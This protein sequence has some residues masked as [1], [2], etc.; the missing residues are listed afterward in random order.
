MIKCIFVYQAHTHTL[1]RFISSGQLTSIVTV[2]LVLLYYKLEWFFWKMKKCDCNSCIR[3]EMHLLACVF[4]ATMRKYFRF[5]FDCRVGAYKHKVPFYYYYVP[6]CEE[7]FEWKIKVSN[8]KAYTFVEYNS[9][10]YNK[11][12]NGTL[13]TRAPFTWKIKLKYMH[14]KH[15]ST[16]IA[17]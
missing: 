10:N 11:L 13:H 14:I 3:V 1:T 6:L 7:K 2:L 15:Q 5:M 12:M 8:G 4:G 9:N 16:A 17:Y